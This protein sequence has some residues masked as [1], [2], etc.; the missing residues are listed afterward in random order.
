[1]DKIAI[2][3]GA[4][5]LAGCQV[6][7]P[8]SAVELQPVTSRGEALSFG[9]VAGVDLSKLRIDQNFCYYRLDA[10]A[11]VPLTS[12][13]GVQICEQNEANPVFVATP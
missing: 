5:F 3:A 8:V 2:L 1:M 4:V 10:G 12:A 9:E 13:S 6:E 11:F 7:P